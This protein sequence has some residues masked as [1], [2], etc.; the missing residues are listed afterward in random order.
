MNTRA[1]SVAPLPMRQPSETEAN[2]VRVELIDNPA[3]IAECESKI[4][5]QGGLF[6]CHRCSDVNSCVVAILIVREYPNECYALC[7]KCLRAL[8]EGIDP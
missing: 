1:K 8:P 3:T 4:L 7:R 5:S 6:V 2:L